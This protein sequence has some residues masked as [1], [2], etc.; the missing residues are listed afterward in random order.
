MQLHCYCAPS[1]GVLLEPPLTEV[2]LFGIKAK[3]KKSSYEIAEYYVAYVLLDLVLQHD[4]LP[5]HI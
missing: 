4:S 2:W 3:K 5:L 1:V